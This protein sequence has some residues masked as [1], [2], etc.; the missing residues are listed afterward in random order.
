MP[1]RVGTSDDHRQTGQKRQNLKMMKL[2]TYR[3]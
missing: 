1:H 3:Q 2:V